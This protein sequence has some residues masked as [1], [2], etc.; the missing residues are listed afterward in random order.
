MLRHSENP[1]D[2]RQGKHLLDSC[3]GALLS[4]HMI[5]RRT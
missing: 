2:A 4:R 5:W 1:T 3:G